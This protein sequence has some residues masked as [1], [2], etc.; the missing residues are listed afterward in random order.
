M[1][2]GPVVVVGGG[3]AGCEAA[4][5]VA[6]VGVEVIL[7]T[8]SHSTIGEMSCNP[9]IGGVGKGH[10]VREID[11]LDGLMG[12]V[13]DTAAIQYRLLNRSRGPAVQGPRVQADRALY[14]A[15]MQAALEQEP[16]EIIEDGVADLLVRGDSVVGVVTEKGREV[17]A[18]KVILTTGTFLRGRIHV[19]KKEVPAGRFGEP[20][21]RALAL[22]L[23]G[24]GFPMGRLKTGT[25]PR[26]QK[27][28]LHWGALEVQKGDHEPV[29]M[30]FLTQKVS[31]PQRP[32]HITYTTP[33][34]HKVI[35]E[36]LQKSSTYVHK[37]S[38]CLGPGPR[39][40]PSIED[41]VA[42]F[43][44]QRHHQVFLEPESLDSPLIYPNG[45]STSLPQEVQLAFLRTI[46]GLEEVEVA[47]WGYAIAY[48]YLDPRDLLPS[49]ESKRLRGLYLAG[50]INGTTGYE[51][52]AAQGLVAGVNAARA[53]KGHPC[54]SLDRSGSYI[55]VLVD[56]LVC[57]G[58]SEPYRMLTARAEY[59]LSLRAD[60]AQARLTGADWGCVRGSRRAFARGRQ[61]VLDAARHTLK[62]L[63]MT[64]TQARKMGIS[65]TQ[66]GVRRSA[67]ELLG[68]VGFEA[69]TPLWPQLKELP[70]DREQRTSLEADSLYAAYLGRQ[71]QEKEMFRRHALE[72]LPQNLDYEQIPGLSTEARQ[73][74]S[75]WR[76]A[77]LGQAARLEGVTPAGVMALAVYM[78]K[79]KALDKSYKI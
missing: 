15:A 3:H 40:C 45:L 71:E 62:G 70:L 27:E 41:K 75:Q 32:C 12:R 73:K 38:G 59:R 56:D 52:A 61:K 22:R 17:S 58:V 29:F 13:A 2:H 46:P 31:A 26:L 7:V 78:R 18:S 9:A 66:D 69:L 25:P 72:P 1:K 10:L 63:E 14:K 74:L 49:L 48:D 24:L 39:Y 19:G 51:E 57:R 16:I 50:Q 5:A 6:R 68:R 11:A 20:P 4:A 28:S 76:P 30:S 55:G 64:P 37:E 47:R 23:Q 79:R 60:N 44:H 67:F 36:N 21:S 33:Q 54:V 53:A 65:M 77:T 42:R 8:H 43:A 35:R 34:T